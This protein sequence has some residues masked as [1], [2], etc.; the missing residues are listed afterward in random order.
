MADILI[1]NEG[2]SIVSFKPVSEK[3]KSWIDQNLELDPRQ[4]LDGAAAVQWKFSENI[5][6]GMEEA[7]LEVLPYSEEFES[8]G[9]FSDEDKKWLGEFGATASKKTAESP[10]LMSNRNKASQQ[11][12]QQ[13]PQAQQPQQQSPQAQ[14][15]NE[16]IEEAP[17][18]KRT[19]PPEL[20]N[21]A[22]HMAKHAWG[23]WHRIS[24]Y[25][26][27][28]DDKRFTITLI[29]PTRRKKWFLLKD[30]ETGYAYEFVTMTEAKRGAKKIF[31]KEQTVPETTGLTPV[32]ASFNNQLL[33]KKRTIKNY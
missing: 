3:G 14:Q 9:G 31:A 8:S 12:Q 21:S 23:G 16:A 11:P 15:P 4:W 30:I 1:E 5:K 13:S 25:T 10:A 33:K 20:P 19:V 24:Q 29:D 28:S 7:G 26:L 22:F 17:G 18:E 27:E 2:G 6:K 32:V